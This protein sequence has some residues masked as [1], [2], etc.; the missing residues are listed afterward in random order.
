MSDRIKYSNLIQ[1]QFESVFVNRMFKNEDLEVLKG[2][3]LSFIY[4]DSTN[5]DMFEAFL[6]VDVLK[7]MITTE[8]QRELVY[9]HMHLWALSQFSGRL[10]LE[11][12]MRVLLW[13][14]FIRPEPLTFWEKCQ[15]FIMGKKW[16]LENRL[17]PKPKSV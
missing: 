15:S 8:E 14:V 6:L 16:V 1:R 17:I 5:D 2:Y 12:S 3:I 13:E 7:E 11:G 4:S 9:H 10:V